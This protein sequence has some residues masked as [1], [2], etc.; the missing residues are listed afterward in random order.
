MTRMEEFVIS[1]VFNLNG[2]SI[3]VHDDLFVN[4]GI[5]SLNFAELICVLEDEFMMVF[6]FVNLLDWNSV[7]TPSGLSL[8]ANLK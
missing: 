4:G 8:F 6:D 5:D 1:W 3:Q 2:K 7:R